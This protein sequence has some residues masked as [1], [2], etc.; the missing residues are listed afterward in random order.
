MSSALTVAVIAAGVFSLALGIVHL[1][2]PRIFALDR[3]IGSDGPSG[4]ELGLIGRGAWTYRRRRSEAI[5]IVWVMSNAASYVLLS[6]GILDLAWAAGHRA[7]PLGIGG[8]WIAG[9][10]A[11]RAGGQFT[12]GRRLGDV[13]IAVLFAVLALLHV[14]LAM[15]A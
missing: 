13:A 15:G 10:W 4:S 9:W 1:W 14:A 2:V 11:L 12:V 6:V 5:G 7:V 3:A 8:L